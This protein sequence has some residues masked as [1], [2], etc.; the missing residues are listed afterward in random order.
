MPP[1]PKP[2]VVI[3]SEP[4]R[5]VLD[6]EYAI[7]GNKDAI[8]EYAA[9]VYELCDLIKKDAKA[10]FAKRDLASL[11]ESS[12]AKI[13]GVLEII[14]SRYELT[15]QESQ[16]QNHGITATVGDGGGKVRITTREFFSVRDMNFYELEG[17][18]RMLKNDGLLNTFEFLSEYQ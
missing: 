3:T 6:G 7:I 13:L 2:L 12:K 1:E 15:P 10:K 5:K 8:E 18:L 9:Q 14:H 17:I 11:S 16:W 4:L